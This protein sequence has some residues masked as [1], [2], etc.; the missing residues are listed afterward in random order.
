LTCALLPFFK[1][2]EQFNGDNRSEVSLSHFGLYKQARLVE[3]ACVIWSHD[4]QGLHACH[5]C[6][7]PDPRREQAIAKI[8]LISQ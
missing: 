2:F 8:G 7:S 1:N 6:H 3:L 5:R 4:E